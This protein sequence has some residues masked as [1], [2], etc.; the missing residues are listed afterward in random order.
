ME[1]NEEKLK[2]ETEE[3]KNYLALAKEG[4]KLEQNQV[5]KVIENHKDITERYH[6]GNIPEKSSLYFK[7]NQNCN[8]T[9]DQ[10]TRVV[11]VL[12]EGCKDC[13][14]TLHGGILTGTVE[15]W[16]CTSVHVHIKTTVNTMQVDI[17][18][19]LFLHYESTEYLGSLVQAGIKRMQVNFK[20]AEHHCF[21]TGLEVLKELHP[22]IDDNIDQFITRLVEGQMLTERILRLAN[23]FPTTERERQAYLEKAE[24]NGQLMEEAMRQMIN[25]PVSSVLKPKDKRELR[26]L[27]AKAEKASQ[28][29]DISVEAKV[30]YKKNE[31]NLAFQEENYQQAAVFYTEALALQPSAVCYSNRSACWLKLGHHDKALDDADKCI[32]LDPSFVK[33]HFRRGLS[34]HALGRYAEAVVSLQRAKDLDPKNKQISAALQVAEFKARSAACAS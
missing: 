23:G 30:T 15:I 2:R 7:G 14:I 33:G 28:G 1:T 34:L 31:G 13:H 26:S 22:D 11:K 19:D 4:Y 17:S 3:K 8:F 6:S 32:E 12:V 16:D 18:E 20:D 29:D 24:K 9:I 27:A 21:N 5:K 25:T 10:D